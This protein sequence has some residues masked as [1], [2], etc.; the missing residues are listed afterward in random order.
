MSTDLVG[1]WVANVS[2]SRQHPLHEYLAA[3]LEFAVD[4]ELVTIDDLVI[5]EVGRPERT[6]NVLQADGQAHPTEQGYVV[7]ARW[8]GARVLEAE[9]TREG[10]LEGR[11]TYEVSADGQTLTVTAGEQVGVFDRQHLN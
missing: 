3:K 5:D 4:G 11:V 9:V 10:A 1:T 8:R 2:A 6:R 7:I